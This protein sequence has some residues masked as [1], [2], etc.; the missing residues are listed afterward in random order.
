M[1]LPD[2][3]TSK[4]RYTLLT[5]S[6]GAVV[7]PGVGN[8]SVKL[9]QGSGDILGGVIKIT[10]ATGIFNLADIIQFYVDGVFIT[11]QYVSDYSRYYW[12]DT[13]AFLLPS[14]TND[15]DE[16]ILSVY[17]YVS[18]NTSF[19]VKYQQLNIWPI[20]FNYSFKIGIY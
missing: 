18:F 3:Y 7:S 1:G 16:L 9:Y 19:E 13:T 10:C 5:S 8:F 12:T 6:I 11:F 2:W 14:Y 20:A 15:K 4:K 17:K